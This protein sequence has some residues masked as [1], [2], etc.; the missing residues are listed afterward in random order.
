MALL[1]GNGCYSDFEPSWSS[2]I[3]KTKKKSIFSFFSS[4][5]PLLPIPFSYPFCFSYIF[6]YPRYPGRLPPHTP[7]VPV[8]WVFRAIISRLSSSSGYKIHPHALPI[9]S[10]EIKSHSYPRLT[11]DAN[12]IK[13]IK[14]HFLILDFDWCPIEVMYTIPIK[15]TSI[16]SLGWFALP[17]RTSL[18]KC[19][20]SYL[21]RG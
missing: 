10:S 19:E 2:Y 9:E 15:W 17:P 20:A 7:S 5:S 21:R 14:V 3:F 16:G 12:Q 8:G 11:I 1:P 6:L 4:T 13:W 18:M